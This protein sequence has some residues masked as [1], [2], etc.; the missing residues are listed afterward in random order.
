MAKPSWQLS[1]TS[2]GENRGT[3]KLS[4]FPRVTEQVSG[5]AGIGTC[6][7]SFVSGSGLDDEAIGLFNGPA[8][9]DFSPVK[10]MD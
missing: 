2:S 8:M 5:G 1:S 6:K 10:L 4:A 3:K 9:S 7:F